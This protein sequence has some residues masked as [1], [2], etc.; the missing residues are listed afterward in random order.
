ML[1]KK[2]LNEGNQIHNF[3][4]CVCERTF[5]IPF[6]SGSVTII[7]YGSGSG[8]LRSVSKLRFRFRYCNKLRF[9]RFRSYLSEINSFLRLAC[10]MQKRTFSS[11]I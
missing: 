3:I 5:V 8:S 2:M 1:M 7:N 6:Y 9:L 10:P 4:L 11:G